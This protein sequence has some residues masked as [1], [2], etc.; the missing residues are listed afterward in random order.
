MPQLYRKAVES[1]G[2]GFLVSVIFFSLLLPVLLF[3][4]DFF[5][6]FNKNSVLTQNLNEIKTAMSVLKTSD[7]GSFINL[8]I[9]V[10]ENSFIYFDNST[11]SIN[12]N[13]VSYPVEADILN[14]LSL[15]GPNDFDLVVF[16]G[17][18]VDL[19]EFMV[20]FE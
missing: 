1:L 7:K 13:N 14:S 3:E 15:K 11:D 2:F 12:I 9:R 8:R 5:A 4:L 16:Y 17:L 18:P 20:S 6:G 10:P 19:K